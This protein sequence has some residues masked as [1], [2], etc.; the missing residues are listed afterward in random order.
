[1]Y[2]VIPAAIAMREANTVSILANG[3]T[4]WKRGQLLGAGSFGKVYAGLDLVSGTQIAVKQVRFPSEPTKRRS[5]EVDALETEIEL[6]RNLDH[7]NIVRYFGTNRTDNRFYIFLE[8]A[9][10]GSVTSAL[11]RFGAFSEAVVRRYTRQIL[12][13]LAYLHANNI[14]HRDIKSSNMLVDHGIVKLSDF[15]CSRKV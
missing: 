9:S 13:G 11:N 4:H 5:K 7:P 12:E 3:I 6:L 14:M 10:D 1:M 2:F 8:Y 15:G